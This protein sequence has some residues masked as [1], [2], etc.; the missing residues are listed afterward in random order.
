MESVAYNFHDED[1]STVG[2]LKLH[3]GDDAVAVQWIDISSELKLYASHKDI[4]MEVLKR[5]LEAV[6]RSK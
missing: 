3:A 6:D 1:G 4:V 5:H 2:K